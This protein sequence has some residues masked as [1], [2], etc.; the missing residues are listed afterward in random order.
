MTVRHGRVR[1]P[2]W[3][4]ILWA[5]RRS[6]ALARLAVAGG[7]MCSQRSFELRGSRTTSSSPSSRP[8]QTNDHHCEGARRTNSRWCCWDAKAQAP[9]K[10]TRLRRLRSACARARRRAAP[11]SACCGRASRDVGVEQ[12]LTYSGRKNACRRTL[13]GDSTS[14]ANGASSFRSQAASGMEKPRSCPS[15]TSGG[16]GRHG[17]PDQA[18]LANLRTFRRAGSA[19][20]SHH[21]LI[22]E[23]HTSLERTRHARPVRLH[24]HVVDEE[25]TEVDVHH[26]GELVGARRSA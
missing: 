10:L 22:Q 16:K 15:R 12:P 7:A 24:K 21:N 18:L 13:S 6:Y 14:R 17:L 19:S 9:R 1:V 3:R 5:R 23:R 26:A 25:D 20:A 8:D 2:C 11:R 4:P